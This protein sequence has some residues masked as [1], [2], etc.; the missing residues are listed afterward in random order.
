VVVPKLGGYQKTV[1]AVVCG[2][3]ACGCA[4][5]WCGVV[6]LVGVLEKKVEVGLFGFRYFSF[7]KKHFPMSKASIKI[8]KAEQSSFYHVCAVFGLLTVQ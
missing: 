3:V 2:V 7:Q 8:S 6:L 1:F 4:C 5:G